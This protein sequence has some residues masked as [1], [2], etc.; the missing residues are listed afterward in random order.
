MMT[1][2]HAAEALFEVWRALGRS[3]Y[4]VHQAERLHS[5]Q[6]RGVALQLRRR[7]LLAVVT[8]KSPP[9]MTRSPSG[10]SKRGIRSATIRSIEDAFRQNFEE[11]CDPRPRCRTGP[12]SLSRD[13]QSE[14]ERLVQE[15]SFYFALKN[16][17]PRSVEFVEVGQSQTQACGYVICLHEVVNV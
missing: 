8:M 9:R 17:F 3:L 11:R 2:R 10:E 5:V 4:H 15:D 12:L 7:G 14:L 6:D 13:T 16:R 1:G